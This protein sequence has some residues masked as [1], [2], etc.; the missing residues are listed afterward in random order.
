MYHRHL[1]VTVL[2]LMGFWGISGSSMHITL[3]FRLVRLSLLQWTYCI[4]FCPYLHGS[5]AVE[6]QA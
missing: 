5:S 6:V 3:T 2:E 1:N 4:F